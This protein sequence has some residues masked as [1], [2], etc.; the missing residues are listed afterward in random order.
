MKT[1]HISWIHTSSGHAA[2]L[3]IS[4]FLIFTIIKYYYACKHCRADREETRKKFLSDRE[5]E[6]SFIENE[7][8]IVGFSDVSEF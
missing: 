4:I 6:E 7:T 3:V 8:D 5:I 2:L 1:A